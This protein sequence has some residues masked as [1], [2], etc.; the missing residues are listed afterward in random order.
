MGRGGNNPHLDESWTAVLNAP[1]GSEL[2]EFLTERPSRALVLWNVE[3][4]GEDDLRAACEAYGPLYY[5]RA[6]HHRKR[7]IFVAYYDVRD[8]IN[9]HRSLGSEVSKYLMS[10]H[11]SRPRPAVHFS[12]ELH[13]GFSYKEGSLVVHNLPAHATE[14]EVAGVFQI[15][16]DLRGIA[17]HHSAPP[18]ASSF[19]V[20]FCSIQDARAAA[21]ELTVRNP[22]GHGIT[23]EPAVRS[24]A[25][26]ALGRQLHSTLNRW[27][28]E[29]A[30]VNDERMRST[31]SS[32]V[33]SGRSS[34]SDSPPPNKSEHGNGREMAYMMDL[35][36]PMTS[37][38]TTPATTPGSTPPSGADAYQNGGGKS[39]GVQ[40]YTTMP[41]RQHYS[42]SA[43][44]S[45][46]SSSRCLHGHQQHS[47][48]RS[49]GGSS[50]APPHPMYAS[51]SSNANNGMQ[52]HYGGGG[53]GPGGHHHHHHHH[54]HPA[55]RNNGHHSYMENGG[56][57]G[58][59]PHPLASPLGGPAGYGPSSSSSGGGGGGGGPNGYW[60]DM[61]PGT[62]LG[63]ADDARTPPT[64]MWPSASLSLSPP[65]ARNGGGMRGSP[66]LRGM[67]GAGG[68]GGLGYKDRSRQMSL[69][70]GRLHGGGGGGCGARTMRCNSDGA[71]QMLMASP[72]AGPE[73]SNGSSSG[74]NGGHEFSLDLKKVSKGMDKRTTIMV[75]NIPNKYTQTMLLQEIDAS[76]RGAYDFFY[77]PIDFKNKCNVGYA[78][79][80][81]I[82]YRRIVPFFREFNAQRWKNFNSEKVCAISYARIQGKASM[83]SRFQNSSLM[84]KDGE[85]RPL[86]FHSTGS[87]RGRPEPFP[88]SSKAYRAV[89][90]L[91]GGGGGMYGGGGRDRERSV[92]NSSSLSMA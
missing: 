88:A 27:T 14:A 10:E 15:Y 46:S 42:G 65:S 80:N 79:I 58:S 77:L 57:G 75:R 30:Q 18:H 20:E 13:A 28:A 34:D 41:L 5:L 62:Y 49:N 12:I 8:A 23:V 47:Q 92:S 32:V 40:H 78:F 59:K 90:V 83:I 19:S 52:H 7:V 24:D 43:G 38:N 44:P 53:G 1:A 31:S 51:S 68:P 48:G 16:G 71:S 84:E 3:A 26:R 29:S 11:G 6:E 60:V 2:M 72:H 66:P 45:S 69:D 37:A 50:S 55:G 81:F 36:T 74:G 56:N 82:D 85:Y 67:P 25:E 63:D 17:R 64:P 9:A 33:M 54:H 22:W 86:I 73:C 61:S 35:Y 21:Q 39:P 76:Y 4:I 89:G 91:P 87:E 70:E